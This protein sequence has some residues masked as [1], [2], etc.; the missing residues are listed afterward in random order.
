MQNTQGKDTLMANDDPVYSF[1]AEASTLVANQAQNSG[2]GEPMEYTQGT[3]QPER[4]FANTQQMFA[5]RQQ[6]VAL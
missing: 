6:I 1:E 2:L 5:N 4:M 3:G